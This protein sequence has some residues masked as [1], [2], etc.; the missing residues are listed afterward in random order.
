MRATLWLT[1]MNVLWVSKGK[2][3]GERIPEKEKEYSEANTIFCGA[4]VGVLAETAR[5]VHLLQN[6]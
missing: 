4:V 6:R 5:Y 2:P 3:K 1:A